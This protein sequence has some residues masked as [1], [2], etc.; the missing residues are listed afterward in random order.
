[1]EMENFP[2]ET[3]D[4]QI[5]NSTSSL[6]SEVNEDIKLGGAKYELRV[7]NPYVTD[8]PQTI[9]TTNNSN[10]RG[11]THNSDITNNV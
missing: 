2:S 1:M 11:I 10:Y 4:L 6:V 3:S 7:Y 9:T 5:E 8:S